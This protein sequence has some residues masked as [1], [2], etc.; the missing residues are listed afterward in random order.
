MM[1]ADRE[2][3]ISAAS[4]LFMCVRARIN[5]HFPLVF[6]LLPAAASPLTTEMILNFVIIFQ[7]ECT[8]TLKLCRPPFTLRSFFC[9]LKVQ[10]TL[11]FLLISRVAFQQR[12][13]RYNLKS[14]VSAKSKL[15]SLLLE[16]ASCLPHY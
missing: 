5:I 14:T 8:K 2:M 3:R 11:N 15:H 9:T 13:K 6:I 1:L 4:E 10:G 16:W 12:T 7:K